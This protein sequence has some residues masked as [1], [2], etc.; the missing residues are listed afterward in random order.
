MTKIGKLKVDGNG[1]YPILNHGCP[2]VYDPNSD[3]HYGSHFCDAARV[4]GP[5]GRCQS[6]ISYNL[7]NKNQ[8]YMFCDNCNIDVCVCCAEKLQL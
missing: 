2:L 4:L 7:G 3:R 8:Q 6:S 5:G 1:R